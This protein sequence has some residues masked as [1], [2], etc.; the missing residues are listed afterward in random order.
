M[1]SFVSRPLLFLLMCSAGLMAAGSSASGQSELGQTLAGTVTKLEAS[2]GGR[3]GVSV[4]DL[5]SGASWSYRGEERFPLAS[6]FKAFACA[7]LLHLVDQKKVVPTKRVVF[8]TSE[9]EAY[10]PVTKDHVGGDG[11][12]LL[13]LCAAATATS[14][15]TA[16]NLILKNTGGPEE[17]TGFLRSLGDQTTRLDRYEPQ[18]NDVGPGETR[19]TTS[20]DAAAQSLHKLLLGDTLSEPS[21][22]Q[23]ENW[24]IA[25]KVGGPLL[26]AVLP[27]GWN[28]ADRTGASDYG[29]RGVLAIMWPPADSRVKGPIV[30]AIYLTGTKL[31]LEDRNV[32]IQGVGAAMLKDLMPD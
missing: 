32:V 16:A 7:H 2:S 1:I 9:L 30:A 6:T 27:A 29:S 25:N 12:S 14:D 28:I 11:M 22:E 8:E 20:P 10:S 5:G 4:T 18:L 26:R 15:N 21:K 13:E 3:I 24:L 31:S 19:D 23:L 17:L